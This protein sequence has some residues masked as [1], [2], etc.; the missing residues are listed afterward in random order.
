M[1]ETQKTNL[2]NQ[3]ITS[4]RIALK[5]EWFSKRMQQLNTPIFLQNKIR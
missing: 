4:L 2:L 1:L 5:K 3:L